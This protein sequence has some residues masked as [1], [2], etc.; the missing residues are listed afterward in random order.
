MIEGNIFLQKTNI[1]LLLSLLL[2]ALL[3]LQR[4]EAGDPVEAG[5]GLGGDPAGD[6]KAEAV[7]AV[8]QEQ[9]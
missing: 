2:N 4:T 7:R 5:L 8:A 9:T 3:L 6:M 1:M